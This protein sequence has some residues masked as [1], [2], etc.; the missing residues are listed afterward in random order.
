MTAKFKQLAIVDIQ[1]SKPLDRFVTYLAGNIKIL[2]CLQILVNILRN[3]SIISNKPILA[4]QF[5]VKNGNRHLT[6]AKIY[7]FDVRVFERC[8][9]GRLR[10]VSTA[11][12]LVC[13]VRLL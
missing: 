4:W 11:F 2:C 8:A 7:Y 9:A 13:F 3:S 5:R 6:N 1:L 12:P 10:K